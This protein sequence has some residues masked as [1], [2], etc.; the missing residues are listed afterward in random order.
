MLEE[1]GNIELSS[2]KLLTLHYSQPFFFSFFFLQM[3]IIDDTCMMLATVSL[4][5]P[6]VSLQVLNYIVD[7]SGI[8]TTEEKSRAIKEA[9]APCNV[10]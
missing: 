6:F 3:Q 4:F 9:T 8:H 7:Q 2:L 1:Q 10:I 5:V